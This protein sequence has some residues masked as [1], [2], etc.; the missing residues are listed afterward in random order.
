[1]KQGNESS[2]RFSYQQGV[3]IVKVVQ[4]TESTKTGVSTGALRVVVSLNSSYFQNNSLPSFPVLSPW[5]RCWRGETNR[6]AA[7][8][9]PAAERKL[10]TGYK[11]AILNWEKQ[12]WAGGGGP[13]TT[14]HPLTAHSGLTPP[15]LLPTQVKLPFCLCWINALTFLSSLK[16]YWLQLIVELIRLLLSPTQSTC[17]R[18]HSFIHLWRWWT[19]ARV[20]L[21]QKHPVPIR[22][23]FL[24]SSRLL[25]RLCFITSRLCKDSSLCCCWQTRL[26]HSR[27]EE[28]QRRQMTERI[29]FF[30]SCLS[31]RNCWWKEMQNEIRQ[32]ADIIERRWSR[33]NIYFQEFFVLGRRADWLLG[34]LRWHQHHGWKT[35]ANLLTA[36]TSQRP[37][38]IQQVLF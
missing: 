14:C 5:A 22:F 24:L 10:E 19:P 18:I 8:F 9:F 23:P 25:Q 34:E 15:V 38:G 33:I 36:A 16:R 27:W 31:S 3:S 26:S 20:Y 37:T 28:I 29:F 35:S 21:L 13:K 7:W 12:L 1:M 32:H 4:T 11:Q 2:S 17:V 6:K 30:S